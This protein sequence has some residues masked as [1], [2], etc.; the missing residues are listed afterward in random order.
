MPYDLS[1]SYTITVFYLA[2]LGVRVSTRGSPR[3][4][5]L[6]AGRFLFTACLR[7]ALPLLR[8]YGCAHEFIRT[9]DKG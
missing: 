6:R 7:L 2:G 3:E 8:G 5:T 9:F 1:M 4:G